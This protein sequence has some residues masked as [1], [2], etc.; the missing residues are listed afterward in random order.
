METFRK[1]FVVLVAS[2]VF[3]IPL[4]EW[5]GFLFA[6][7]FAKTIFFITSV[8]L[9]LVFWLPIALEYI[10][11]YGRGLLGFF[12]AVFFLVAFVA[13]VIG[14][15]FTHSV[16]S[17]YE[18]MFGL[19]TLGHLL[20][21]FFIVATTLVRREYWLWPMRAA[22]SGA[23]MA[24][25]YAVFEFIESSGATRVESTL[26]NASFLASYLL[27]ASFLCLWLCVRSGAK[28]TESFWWL[29]CWLVIVAALV[30]TGSR[31]A[32]L[33]LGFTFVVLLAFFLAF[34]KP[35]DKTA[36]INNKML[37]RYAIS[38]L[39]AFFVISVGGFV[40]REQLAKSSFDPLS[41]LASISLSESTASGRL[42]A[43]Q[44]SWRGW[45]E[46]PL[47]GWGWENYQILFDRNY[48]PKLVDQEPWFD[49]AH[50][51]FLDV[52]STTGILGLAAYL[53]MFFS[54]IFLLAR[55]WRKGG[56]GFWE[57]SIFSLTLVAHIVQGMFMFDFLMSLILLFLVFA[58]IHTHKYFLEKPIKSRVPKRLTIYRFIASVIILPIWF[59]GVWYPLRENR[60][61]RM[62]YDAFAAGRDDEA[63]KFFEEALSYDTYGNIDARRS[64][65]E[66]FTR[67]LKL[68]GK[69]DQRSLAR[70]MNYAIDKMEQN[71]LEDSKNVKWYMYQGELLNLGAV[72]LDSPNKEYARRAEERFTQALRLSPG[73]PQ[74]YLEIAQARKI[75]GNISGMWETLDDGVRIAPTYITMH[76]N[77]LAHAIEVGDRDR[78]RREYETIS[79]SGRTID[80]TT[81]RDAYYK[82]GRISDAI[83]MQLRFIEYKTKN[84][85]AGELAPLYQTLA[86][87][88]KLSGDMP[89]A[90]EAALKV[91]ELNPALQ[92]EVDAFLQTLK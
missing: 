16:W 89:R 6:S 31:G 34:A 5:P 78:E 74:I 26:R 8:E 2:I 17:N 25:T 46:R 27:L 86:A 18:R 73:R 61:A 10:K 91:G 47:L 9:M 60:L 62:G 1:I 75:Q 37:K 81:I 55:G 32:M 92:K 19:W 76:Y 77:A 43:W 36:G 33:A 35:S 3:L 68:G 87:L 53:G 82:K 45:K 38:L 80:Y 14:S 30:L 42:L 39:I 52:G 64:V 85:D 29:F 70:V 28:R 12:V 13:S 57:F 15:D 72:I 88:Y 59:F 4:I 21:F 49:R 63:I 69:R 71:I 24:A 20:A 79:A 51:I 7:T 41:R 83:D 67:F 50:N 11:N 44:V 58:F 56:V 40:F 65:A 48:D 22:T 23:F 66:Y 54:A 90:R 84:T